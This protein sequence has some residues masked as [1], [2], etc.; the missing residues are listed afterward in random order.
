M[1]SVEEPGESGFVVAEPLVVVEVLDVPVPTSVVLVLDDAAEVVVVVLAP[2]F[3][4]VLVVGFG[5]AHTVVVVEDV[6]GPGMLVVVEV[7]V[8][9]VVVAGNEASIVT[10]SMNRNAFEPDPSPSKRTMVF[11]VA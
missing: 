6:G 5:G 4:V 1:E 3:K 2:G 9:V 8:V 10:S 11:D 7:D